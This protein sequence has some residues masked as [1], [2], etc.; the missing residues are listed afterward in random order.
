MYILTSLSCLCL[1][2]RWGVHACNDLHSTQYYSR[3]SSSSSMPHASRPTPICPALA[4]PA[5]AH[6]ISS[7]QN[8]PVPKPASFPIHCPRHSTP[9]IITSKQSSSQTCFLSHPLSP[10][11]LIV[12]LCR[13]PH[14]THRNDGRCTA[15]RQ[16]WPARSAPCSSQAE[17]AGLC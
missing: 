3:S 12:S 5:T 7:L 2:V 16:A 13:L 4:Q 6:P 1:P 9:N 8:N 17:E 10:Q 14:T 11:P 15:T